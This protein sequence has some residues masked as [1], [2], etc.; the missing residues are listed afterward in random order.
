MALTL[1][2]LYVTA[3]HKP[4]PNHMP[5]DVVATSAQ[6]QQIA[7]GL[8]ARVGNVLDITTVSSEAQARSDVG[9]MD[10]RGALDLSNGHIYKAS[11][12]S[13]IGSEAVEQVLTRVAGQ[14]GQ[15]T[16][17]KVT[18]KVI[19]LKPLP[20]SDV[21][22][23]SLLF[24]AMGGILAGFVSA[25]LVNLVGRLRKPREILL[26]AGIAVVAGMV[27]T[28]IAYAGYGAFDDHLV[29]AGLV[30]AAGTFTVSL[31]Q[32]GGY[33]LIGPVMVY[34]GVVLFVFLGIPASGAA[35][36]IDMTPSFFQAISPFLPTPAMLDMLRRVLYFN[37]VGSGI[38]IL[39][40]AV[41]ACIAIGLMWVGHL[42]A[43]RRKG[44]PADQFI[45]GPA[46]RDTSD[47]PRHEALP[48][49][50]VAGAAAS[51]QAGPEGAR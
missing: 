2:I 34:A 14:V 28:L 23:L 27:T 3:F 40:L 10:A 7:S 46:P 19:D 47:S 44:S 48:E 18:P 50:A 49:T 29:R 5:V 39:T 36:P 6:Q 9:S 13:I 15:Q 32:T 43:D 4:A 41:W 33:K 51:G 25:S 1:P 16:G 12:G 31:V 24:L 30:V 8:Q 35:V 20:S 37:S 21:A 22:G 42:V 38:D 17:Q 26:Y 45:G 11:A